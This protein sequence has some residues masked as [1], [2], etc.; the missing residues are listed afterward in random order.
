MIY[1]EWMLQKYGSGT[2]L[3][4]LISVPQVQGVII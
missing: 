3:A 4:Q 2:S 1:K